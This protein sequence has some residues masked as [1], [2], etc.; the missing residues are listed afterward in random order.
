MEASFN[1]WRKAPFLEYG[2]DER[3]LDRAPSVLRHT[4]LRWHD[5]PLEVERPPG[6][7]AVGGLSMICQ[8]VKLQQYSK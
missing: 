1:D 2:R 7:A 6:T 3:I 5:Y 8:V 4:Q